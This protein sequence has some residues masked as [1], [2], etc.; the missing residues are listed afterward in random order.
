[1]AS[2]IRDFFETAMEELQPGEQMSIMCKDHG[3]ANSQRTQLYQLLT[4]REKLFPGTKE[5]YTAR[6]EKDLQG[7]V[8]TT[9]VFHNGNRK[10]VRGR[11][12][13]TDT[14]QPQRTFEDASHDL[15]LP[16]GLTEELSRQVTYM[17][18]DEFLEKDIVAH[19][20]SCGLEEE[21]AVSHVRE[22]SEVWTKNVKYKAK[23]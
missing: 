23:K 17:I 4:K 21:D 8:F 9:L 3:H 22:M 11:Y 20:I 14:K 19:L 12:I 2:V 16:P 1:M 15:E 7:N 5:K 13:C 6:I 18:R 10:K